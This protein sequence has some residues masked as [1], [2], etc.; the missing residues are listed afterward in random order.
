MNETFDDIAAVELFRTRL[1]RG[2]EEL[3]PVA[4]VNAILDGGNPLQAWREHR[5]LSISAL[6]AS[7][8]VTLA[9]L[10]QIESGKREGTIDMLRKIAAALNVMSA[11]IASAVEPTP[12]SD[13][14]RAS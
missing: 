10:S 6:A 2:E 3:L 9:Y 5:G 7:A 11:D 1:S 13:G 12:D 8:G 4:L 14:A